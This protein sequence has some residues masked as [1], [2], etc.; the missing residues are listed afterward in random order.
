MADVV[1]HPRVFML[2]AAAGMSSGLLYA[3]LRGL[4]G[5]GIHRAWTGLLD[6]LFIL[7]AGLLFGAC[8]AYAMM[9]QIRLFALLAFGAG[10]AVFYAGPGLALRNAVA[11]ALL[12]AAKGARRAGEALNRL[13]AGDGGAADGEG[14]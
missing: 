8:S 1:I 10:F 13:L 6:L 14:G 9:G 2:F 11:K 12:M 5:R 3:L 4:H 7:C